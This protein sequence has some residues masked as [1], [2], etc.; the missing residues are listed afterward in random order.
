MNINPRH[1]IKFQKDQFNAVR[2]GGFMS[3]LYSVLQKDRPDW[4]NEEEVRKS[5]LKHIENS[6]GI[7]FHAERGRNDASYNQVIIEFKDRG[8]FKGSIK[9]AAFKEAIFDR[10]SKYISRRAKAE[11][12]PQEDYIGI[13]TDGDHISFAFFKDGQIAHRNLLPF[14][15]ASIGL[16]AQACFDSKRRAVTAEN[17]VEDFGHGSEI[18][19]AM[20]GGLASELVSQV[21]KGGNS[22]IKMLFEEW[23]TLFGQVADLSAAQAAEIKKQI[24][25]E[26]VLPKADSV[27]ALLFV[28][29]TYNA[30]VMKLLAAEIV[31][32]YKLTAH[33][34]FCEHLLGYGDD[35]LLQKLDTEVERSG[36]FEGARIKG[37]VEE[38]VFSWYT[39][40]SLSPKGRAGICDGIR[41]FLT[42]L[43]LYR[44]DDLSAARSRDVLK[45]FY[46]ALVPETLR[47]ALGEF[48]TPDWLVDIACDR[49]EVAD[50]HTARVLDPT[51]GSGS[52]LLE[53]IRRKRATGLKKKLSPQAIL[54]N[55][56]ETVW[57]FDLNPLAVQSSRV[58]FLIAIA[59]LVGEA[60]IEVELP[61]LLAD[62]VYS[63]AHSPQVDKDYVEYR[64][65]SAHSDLKVILPWALAYDRKRLDDA[66]VT[67]A[68]AVDDEHPY[69]IVEKRL[70]ERETITPAEAAKWRDAL[71]DTYGQVL[72][73]HKKSWNGIWFRIVRNFFWS[74]VAGEFD[75]VI[76]NPPWVRWSNLPEMYRERIKPTCEQYAIFSETPFHGG[77]E[78]DISGMLTYTVGDKWLKQGGTL[79]FVITQTH[80]QSPSSQG[81]RS[82]TINDEANLIPVG[83][84]D[85]KKLKPFS[86][87]ANK[88]A[89]MRLHKVPADQHTSYPVPYRVWEKADGF[90]ASIP[91]TSQ[92]SEIFKRVAIKPWEATPVDGGNSPWAILPKGRFAAMGAIQ[93]TSDWLAGRK[94][95]TTDLNGI[96]IVRILATNKAENLVQIQTR[97]DAGRSDIGPARTF[98]IEPDLLYPLLKGAGDFSACDLHVEEELFVLV[99]NRAIVQAA[100]QAAE[101]QLAKLKATSS[102]FRAFKDRLSQRSTYRLRQKAAPYYAI[103]NVGA[104]SFAPFKVVWAELSTTF[105]AVVVT[106]SAVPLMG[107]RPYVPDHKVYFADFED[108]STAY[109][110][111]AMLNSSM[112]REYVES[113]TIQ[114]QVSN[115]FKHLSIP[116]FKPANAQHKVIVDLCQ[117]AH[118]AK[119][120]K[121]KADLL[122]KLDVATEALLT[123]KA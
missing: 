2:P 55:V 104:Y 44:M 46:Q 83:I 122:A 67:M 69:P 9:S 115:I 101:K 27:A 28:I 74:A 58:N 17:L 97:P 20:M 80:F 12:I 61:V 23:R 108:E 107:D 100:Y 98:W 89:I 76:G 30:F 86:K 29:H 38:A 39:D 59:D 87:V 105:E 8:L 53:A 117:K 13:A 31:A 4:A 48:Y 82:F 84:D 119:T 79:V 21:N 63:P 77:N 49:A 64:I 6:L 110:V 1:A 111:C 121:T 96:Y 60:K 7:K 109:F 68:E 103:Y 26:L 41:S 123:A 14:N 51:C 73:L 92:K 91:E 93:G 75:V 45:A 57:G 88:T 10:L 43:S 40:I 71:S 25:L 99:P 94:G 52:F 5:W 114:I 56:L 37:F 32:E 15:E 47:K 50:W 24:P 85:L 112:V 116:H 120:G 118:S 54:S 36:Y 22:K 19:R 16:V 90:S 33:P 18:G 42:Q 70:L 106:K 113:H 72:E 66:F 35:D 102:Y 34:D 95:V 81:F 3:S 62:A 65:G 78:L 11:E